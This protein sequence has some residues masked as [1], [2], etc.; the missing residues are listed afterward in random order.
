MVK[1]IV[2][3]IDTGIRFGTIKTAPSMT[4][5]CILPDQNWA[6][7]RNRRHNNIVVP[8]EDGHTTSGGRSPSCD[9]GSFAYGPA[10]ASLG[11]RT[12]GGPIGSSGINT[13]KHCHTAT[14]YVQTVRGECLC[15]SRV[16]ID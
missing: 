14:G 9:P 8:L 12:P 1:K 6:L 2:L 16:V 11:D 3:K 13:R 7:N 15:P 10:R 5:G 4:L